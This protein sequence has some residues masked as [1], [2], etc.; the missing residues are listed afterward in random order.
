MGLIIAVAAGLAWARALD[1]DP[2]GSLADFRWAPLK[3]AI[4]LL[5][6]SGPILST[7]SLMVLFLRL[8]RPRPAR[9]RLARQPGFL[10]CVI[11]AAGSVAF[12]ALMLGVR[13]QMIAIDINE[14]EADV[15][16]NAAYFSWFWIGSAIFG[17][18]IG[19]GLGRRWRPEPSW[20]DRIGRAHGVLWIACSLA[21][22]L[23]FV[24]RW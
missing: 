1:E 9:R 8:R 13:Y 16:R 5:I 20:I 21:I 4:F 10:A 15:I 14:T 22:F 19:L 6:L 18:W 24:F 2:L 23:A 7:L 3:S 11:A 12:G 17:A